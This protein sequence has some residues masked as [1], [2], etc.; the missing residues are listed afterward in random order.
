[1]FRA[2]IEAEYLTLCE[3]WDRVFQLRHWLMNGLVRT[4]RMSKSVLKPELQ[5]KLKR[6]LKGEFYLR[7]NVGYY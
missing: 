1:M 7:P 6:A 2:N 4:E 5:A 3:L